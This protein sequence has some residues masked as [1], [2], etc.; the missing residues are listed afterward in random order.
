MGSQNQAWIQLD[1][2]IT[3]YMDEAE[4]SNHKY[5][6]LWHLGFR[7]MTELGIDA[8]YSIKSVKLPVNSNLTVTLPANYLKISKVGVFNQQGNVIPLSLNNNLSTAFDLQPTRLAQTQDPSIV[9]TE[10][11]TGTGWYNYWNGYTLGTLYGVPSGAPFVGS[12]KIDNANGVIVLSES[13]SYEYV[14]LEYVPS[15]DEGGEYYVPIQF[16][17]AIIAYLRWKD[18]ISM[19]N[20]RKGTLGDKQMRRKDFYNERRLAIARFDPVNLTD[21]YEWNLTNQRISIKS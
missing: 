10:Q 1:E 15:P 11:Q 18:I 20:S 13:F 3:A 12:Y 8:F 14:V 5:Y 7:A 16:K 4:L 2:C 19:P 17:E 6:K 9:T 21:G